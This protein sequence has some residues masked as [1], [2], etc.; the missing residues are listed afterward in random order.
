MNESI[1][2]LSTL[3]RQQQHTP[4]QHPQ[5]VGGATIV[6]TVEG[7]G[8]LGRFGLGLGS[9]LVWVWIVLR[10]QFSILF[11]HTTMAEFRLPV[12]LCYYPT[13]H[14]RDVINER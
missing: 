11:C 6:A 2:R 12:L 3:L 9:E 1:N 7:S 5:H 14:A 10:Y 13:F 4:Q 8:A